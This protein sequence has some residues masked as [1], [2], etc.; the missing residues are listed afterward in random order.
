MLNKL[1]KKAL[2]NDV[3]DIKQVET[4]TV[5]GTI[6]T[7]GD[8]TVI[9]T[10]GGITGSPF[11]L[12]VAV[13][14]DDTASEVAEKIKTAMGELTALV[15]VWEIGGTGADITLTRKIASADDTDLNISIANDTCAGLTDAV[16]SVDT[17]AGGINNKTIKF[18][19]VPRDC[20]LKIDMYYDGGTITWDDGIT[21]LAEFTPTAGKTGQ[22]ELKTHDG[23]TTWMG[24]FIG[25][26]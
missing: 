16:A 17:T 15:A 10:A 21:W 19:N 13:E 3:Y 4:A 2:I 14:L 23:G 9:V 6:T 8:A 26:W 24:R 11:T 1:F 7:A 25:E 22:Y 5:V 18:L 20:E 12:H